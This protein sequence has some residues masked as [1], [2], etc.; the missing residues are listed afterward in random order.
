VYCAP[1]SGG[2][3]QRTGRRPGRGGTTYSSFVLSDYDNDTLTEIG[4]V[5]RDEVFELHA[6]AD[7]APLHPDD[8]APQGVSKRVSQAWAFQF[9]YIIALIQATENESSK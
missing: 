4:T 6:H 9:G 2:F 8:V 1:P 3:V 7:H 5:S